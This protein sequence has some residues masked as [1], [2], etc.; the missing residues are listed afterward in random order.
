MTARGL[1]TW[2]GDT[3][4]QIFPTPFQDCGPTAYDWVVSFTITSAA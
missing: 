1:G 4:A 2:L 3:R